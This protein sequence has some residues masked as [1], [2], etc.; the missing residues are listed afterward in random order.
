LKLHISGAS[1]RLQFTGYGEGFVLVNAQRHESSLIVTPERAIAWPVASFGALA[2]GHFETLAAL[3]VEV[4]LLG[5]GARQRFP[6]AALSA[7]LRAARIGFEVMD[8]PAACRTY[9]ILL[10]EARR[11]AAALILEKA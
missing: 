8:V 5:T 3:E 10:A 7:P 9:N 11:V 1:A 4:V 2:S 6:A